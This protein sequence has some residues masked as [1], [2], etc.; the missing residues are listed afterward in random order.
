MIVVRPLSAAASLTSSASATLPWATASHWPGAVPIKEKLSLL[1]GPNPKGRSSP[2]AEN[3]AAATSFTLPAPA[4]MTK[5]ARPVRSLSIKP[6]APA[7]APWRPGLSSPPK[8]ECA[9][10]QISS[11]GALSLRIIENRR[12][13]D[14]FD[15]VAT[16]EIDGANALAHALTPVS[17]KTDA[18]VLAEHRR[19]RHRGK[20]ALV[21][22]GGRERAHWD[23]VRACSERLRRVDGLHADQDWTRRIE[24]CRPL[25]K[26]PAD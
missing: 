7:R 13:D 23:K 6:G 10:R 25:G 21:I 18:D 14:A 20:I 9:W 11:M 3:T 8:D 24:Q 5:S 1:P 26:H 12:G 15:V 17:K 16:Q 19:K 4:E 22:G 2:V